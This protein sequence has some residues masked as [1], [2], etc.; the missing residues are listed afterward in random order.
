[1]HKAWSGLEEVPYCF[2]RSSVK[3]QGHISLKINGFD[4]NWV[5]QDC[6]CHLNSQMATKW[7]TQLEVAYKRC[8]IV[9]WLHLSNFKVTRNEKL[10]FWL[11]FESFHMTTLLWIQEWLRNDTYSFWEHGRGSLFFLLVICQ[12]SRSH[13]SQIEFDLIWAR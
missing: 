7:C 4:P 5:L 8:P 13:M 9:L 3:F 12:I 11:W 6:N 10:T 1:M 2:S